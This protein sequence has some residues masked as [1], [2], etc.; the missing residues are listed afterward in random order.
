ML[1]T[2][3]KKPPPAC[4]GEAEQLRKLLAETRQGI[5]QLVPHVKDQML[6]QR[7]CRV[8]RGIDLHFERNKLS[9]ST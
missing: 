3:G 7:L 6:Y 2:G 8:M 5:A 1:T 9:C 4:A